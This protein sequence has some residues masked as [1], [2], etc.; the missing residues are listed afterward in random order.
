MQKYIRS[1]KYVYTAFALAALATLATAVPALAEANTPT[2]AGSAWGAGLQG[3]IGV[4]MGMQGRGG[5]RPTV[6]GTVSAISGDS[7]TVSGRAGFGPNVTA[8]I[9]TYTVDATNAKITKAGVASSLSSIIVGDTIVVEGTVN[10]TNITATTIR[11]GV[12][13][14]GS[15]MMKPGVFGKVTVVSGNIITVAGKSGFGT[16]ATNVTYTVDATNA[17]VMK[18]GATSSVSNIAVGDSISAQG[19]LTGTNLVATTI[20]DGAIPAGQG[21]GSGQGTPPFTGNGEPIVAGS[22]TAVSGNTITITNK[23]NVTYTIDA[24]NAK[25][26]KGPNT[27][28]ISDVAVGDMIVAQG[29]VNGNAVVATSVIDQ[30]KAGNNSQGNEGNSGQPQPHQGGGFFGGIG[31]FFAHIFGF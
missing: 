25:I 5:M 11:D 16:N 30:S 27:S 28:T 18:N 10:G 19:T 12:M 9:T 26:T 20:R 31:S 15:G 8:T 6:V 14:G 3:H 29:T 21:K 17:T 23:S 7:I 4:G 2:N 24:T 1:K 13:P 22:V